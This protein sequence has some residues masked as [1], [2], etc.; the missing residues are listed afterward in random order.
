MRRSAT[1]MSQRSPYQDRRELST[2]FQRRT[3][4][5]NRTSMMD[6]SNGLMNESYN[7]DDDDED[8]LNGVDDLIFALKS[9]GNFTPS[10]HEGFQNDADNYHDDEDDAEI[11][12]NPP[13]SS[14]RYSAVRRI[15]MSDTPL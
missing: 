12:P 13:P 4:G 10:I 7:D 14:E 5:G 3:P 1:P 15:K 8:H 9:S 2:N 6:N 11:F